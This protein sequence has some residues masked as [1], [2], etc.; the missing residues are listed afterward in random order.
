MNKLTITPQTMLTANEICM[1]EHYRQIDENQ[2]HLLLR[3][4]ST[5]LRTTPHE[6]AKPELRVVENT[7]GIKRSP[8]KGRMN[9]ALSA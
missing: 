1:L 8:R 2:Q 5:L 7:T 4:L 6:R 9:K 3:M